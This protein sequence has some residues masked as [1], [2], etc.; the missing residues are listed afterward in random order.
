MLSGLV[1]P[2][3]NQAANILLYIGKA[4]LCFLL[5]VLFV[6]INAGLNYLCFIQ[7]GPYGAAIGNVI[8]T[9][10][11]TIV[12]YNILKKSIG[13]NFSNIWKYILDTI[14][15]IMEKIA[16]LVKAKQVQL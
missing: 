6:G 11:G 14:K 1:K 16:L 8:G 15:T 3:Q 10:L 2:I 4:R 13:V 5:N 12:W 7:F 9:V